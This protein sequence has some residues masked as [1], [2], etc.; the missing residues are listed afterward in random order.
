M[1][2]WFKGVADTDWF[3]YV[4]AGVLRGFIEN[5]DLSSPIFS[6]ILK[7]AGGT[8]KAA[9]LKAM[10]VGDKRRAVQTLVEARKNQPGAVTYGLH[11]LE[12]FVIALREALEAS[13]ENRNFTKMIWPGVKKEAD[14]LSPIA[15][16]YREREYE[17]YREVPM[18]R[19]RVDALCHKKGGFLRSEHLLAIELKN[20]LAQLKRG[21]DQM[22]TFADYAHGVYLA[23]TPEMAFN[24]LQ[25]HAKAR[26]VHKWDFKALE[27]KLSR[28]GIGLLIVQ[29]GLVV[30]M[31]QAKPSQVQDG[32]RAE[33]APHM[34]PRNTV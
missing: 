6:L 33:I 26:A 3:G 23:C 27:N 4:P 24:F 14:L 32:K 5:D 17:V 10:S 21:F 34:I 31:L 28:A 16:Y 11:E 30:N 7:N 2:A 25:D 29:E 22:T 9:S 12:V 13:K 20:D 19:K 15:A 8:T 1:K 18:G